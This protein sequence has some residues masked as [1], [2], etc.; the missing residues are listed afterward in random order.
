MQIVNNRIG[1]Y[2]P[3][4]SRRENHVIA[5]VRTGVENIRPP[6]NGMTGTRER[7]SNRIDCPLIVSAMILPANDAN[8]T[9]WPE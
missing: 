6:G 9:P 1:D 5:S 4:R 8:A 3:N 7:T 2:I